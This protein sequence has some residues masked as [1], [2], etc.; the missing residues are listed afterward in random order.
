MG[1]RRFEGQVAIVTGSAWGMGRSHAERLAAEGARVVLADL[2]EDMAKDV[3]AGLPDAIA[4]RCEI[5]RASCR[6][7]VYVLV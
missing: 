5:G 4:L 1:A 3:A 2:Q 6:E 7:R